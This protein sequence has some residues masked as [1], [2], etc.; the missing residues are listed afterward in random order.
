M[1]ESFD[2][3]PILNTPYDMPTR[4]WQLDENCC[5][6]GRIED[7]R[8]TSIHLVPIPAS[9]QKA[10]QNQLKLEEDVK[11]NPIINRI[12]RQLSSWR[13][14]SLDKQNVTYATQ[15]LLSHWR[16]GNTTPRP[17]FCQVEAAETFI[18][19]NEVAPHT[20]E[21]RRILEE[22]KE[23]NLE[24]NPGLL[25]YAAKMATGS[26]K[27]TVMAMLIAYHTIN[28]VRAPKSSRFSR[29][30][31]IIAPGITI[32]DRLRVL[33]PSDPDNMYNGRGVVPN[34]FLGD[35]NYA[36]IIVTNYH[37]FRCR[38]KIK[39]T[40]KIRDVLQGNSEDQVSMSETEGEMIAR[41]CESLY[42]T[43]N[44]IVINDEAHHCYRY[45]V[46]TKG[47]NISPDEKK[48]LEKNNEVARL[49]ISGIE[50]IKRKIGIKYIYD[51]SA[52]PFFLQGSGYPEGRLFPWV[53]SDFA[54]MDAIECGIVKLPRVPIDDGTV[55]ED[56]LPIYRNIYKHIG[57]DLRK[58]R[59]K[60][61]KL[62]VPS[63]YVPPQLHGAI[64]ALYG[65]YKKTYQ[66]WEENEI[67]IPPVFIIVCNN[68]TTSKLILDLVAGYR[69]PNEEKKYIR[70]EFDLFSNIG[71]DKKP[72]PEMRT[73]LIDSQ[74]LDRG[75]ALSKDFKLVAADEI[76]VFKNEM[77]KRFPNKDV[78]NISDEE[79]LREV[80]NTVGKR[81]RLGEKIRC[82]ISVSMLTE[83]WDTNNVTH[84][85]GVRAFGTQ[86]LCEQVV[87]RGLRRYSYDVE[88]DGPNKGKFTPEYADIL[89]VPFTF[90]TGTKLNTPT[91]PKPQHRV[92]SLES[93]SHLAIKFPQVRSY[94]IKPKDQ[95]IVANFDAD[96]QLE[97]TPTDAPHTTTQTA[98]IGEGITL[99]LNDLRKRRRNEIVYRLAAEIAQNYRDENG[100]IPP[101]IFQELAPIVRRWM[102]SCL[103]CKEGTF[104]Q[105]LLIKTLQ[106]EAARRIYRACLPQEDKHQEIFVP[107]LD[108]FCPEGSTFDVDFYTRKERR[109]ST[110]PDKCHVNLAVCDSNWE[111]DFC[112]ILEDTASVR[113]YIRNDQ[114]GFEVPYIFKEKA[115]NY[116]PDFIAV[117]DDNHESG[118]LLNLIIEIKGRRGE[119]DKVKAD[120]VRR[121][122]LPSVNSDGRWGR[123]DFIEITSIK[124]A[125][126]KLSGFTKRQSGAS[127]LADNVR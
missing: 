97:I 122:W 41:S 124:E 4:H 61:H 19:L 121:C 20:A 10:A 111:L 53:T 64:T 126:F 38:E 47:K 35:I 96:S 87:G 80:M 48:D 107:I 112:K 127:R 110:S 45:K 27:T 92:M 1:T 103:D 26:G 91:P 60:S 43:R 84:I 73:L 8:R 71:E 81:G 12:R 58:R 66:A 51:L 34:E 22:I 40:P 49:W 42:R 72:L 100:S 70:G 67:G 2:I 56:N 75:E 113:S 6:T 99:D 13:S 120:T 125:R 101:Q 123:W 94:F 106:K 52:T 63:A 65:H 114:L 108:R 68:T 95:K 90:A 69:L 39:I 36:N 15:K 30:F 93:R 119:V 62:L 85:L 104:E 83:G 76:E 37:A 55:T 44:I 98:I 31:L 28:S 109:H 17:F 9:K 5:P 29:N 7:G 54:L 11:E 24:A 25:R 116:Q 32:K 86:L 105:Y 82:V 74:Q 59:V 46:G 18:W 21:G 14:K 50:A 16:E 77:R 57:K 115:R 23:A 88:T 117:I 78:E 33:L 79:I 102:R 3:N 89:G 118:E